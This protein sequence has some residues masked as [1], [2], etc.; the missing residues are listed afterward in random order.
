MMYG[1]TGKV[2]KPT[3]GLGIRK[4]M[5]GFAGDIFN[6][7]ADPLVIGAEAGSLLN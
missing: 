1:L 5:E 4:G 3:E 7:A 2:Q 6:M